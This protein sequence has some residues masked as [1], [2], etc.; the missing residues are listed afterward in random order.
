MLAGL[1]VSLLWVAHVHAQNPPSFWHP[2]RGAANCIQVADA[3]GNFNCSPLATIDPA[4]GTINLAPVTDIVMFYSALTAC[5]SDNANL[6]P[7]RLAANDWALARTAA[8]AET[9]NNVCTLRI[10]TRTPPG[11]GYK[12]TA[13]K[14][15]QQITVAALTSNTFNALSRTSYVNNVANAVTG[16]GGTITITM[17]TATQAN[18][19]VTSGGVGT[20][21]FMNQTDSAINMDFTAVMA[22]TGVYRLYGVVAAWTY[23]Q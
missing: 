19:Y 22:N 12:L 7:A 5:R 18:P 1:A 14:I 2:Y 11:E 21:A 8:G 16:Y 6:V 3:Q 23:Q 17:P 15:V 4:T 10:P 20:P 9:Y 13:F